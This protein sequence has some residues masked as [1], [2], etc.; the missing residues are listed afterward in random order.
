M[1]KNRKK[2][3]FK[4]RKFEY[5]IISYLWKNFYEKKSFFSTSFYGVHIF[6]ASFF[7]GTL[8]KKRERKNK[9]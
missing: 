6:N 2:I 8:L 5:R 3:V 9:D 4:C 7:I 1:L